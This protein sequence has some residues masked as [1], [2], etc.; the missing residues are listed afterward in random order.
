MS[1][2]HLGAQID[3]HGGGEDLIFPH[4]CSEIAQSEAA[5]GLQ[6]FVGY[7]MHV[8]LVFM[9]GEKMSKSLGNLAFV[10]DLTPRFGGNALRYYLLQHPYRERLSYVED[11]LA[12]AAERW[13]VMATTARSATA[14]DSK[15]LTAQPSWQAFQDAMDDDLDTHAALAV[16]EDVATRDPTPRDRAVLAAMLHTLGFRPD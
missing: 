1:S 5:T 13:E 3:I 7:W 2:R 12:R 4:H 15:E 9:D 6:P 16:A 11:D 8:G 10:R 14:P